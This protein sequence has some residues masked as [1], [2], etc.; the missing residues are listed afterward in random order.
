MLA[1]KLKKSIGISDNWLRRLTLTRS[2]VLFLILAVAFLINVLAN[3][4]LLQDDK[5]PSI[6]QAELTRSSLTNITT[7]VKQSYMEIR[8]VVISQLTQF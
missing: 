1:I 3:Q 5:S 2:M 7:S 8:T 6:W 4:P